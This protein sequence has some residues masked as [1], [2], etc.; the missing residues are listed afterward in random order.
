M[1]VKDL[2]DKT[3]ARI[4]VLELKQQKKAKLLIQKEIDVLSNVL[5]D[6]MDIYQEQNLSPYE[7]MDSRPEY[8]SH[9]RLIFD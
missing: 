4:S 5:K 9:G 8:L 2:M 6:L 7:E 3:N 1:T